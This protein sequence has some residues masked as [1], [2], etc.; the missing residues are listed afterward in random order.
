MVAARALHVELY[1]VVAVLMPR[2]LELP[3]ALLGILKAGGAYL[4]LDPE[5]PSARLRFMLEDADA[6]VLV[7]HSAL[8]ARQLEWRS[9]L[10]ATSNAIAAAARSV[11]APLT[12][13]A[14]AHVDSLFGTPQALMSAYAIEQQ[15]L[16]DMLKSILVKTSVEVAMSQVGAFAARRPVQGAFALPELLAD[17]GDDA[18]NE[19]QPLLGADVSRMVD[20]GWA[21]RVD[22]AEQ[23]WAVHTVWAAGD[24]PAA[25]VM[26]YLSADT[27]GAIPGIDPPGTDPN[28]VVGATLRSRVPLVL[29]AWGFVFVAVGEILL[30]WRRS[31]RK[32]IAA[33]PAEPDPAEKLLEELLSQVEAQRSAVRSQKSANNHQQSENNL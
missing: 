13:E 27:A 28:D 9:R 7:T 17:M 33:K 25:Y 16:L 4:P 19:A 1:R 18:G 6:L 14:V 10:T 29:A 15:R 22:P 8:G 26:T 12:A 23:V 21:L 32:L 11:G 30:Y 20:I 2:C 24:E 31:R 3:V 5:L